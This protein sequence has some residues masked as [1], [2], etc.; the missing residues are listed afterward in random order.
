MYVC[1]IESCPKE[2]SKT[3]Y[4]ISSHLQEPL[5]HPWEELIEKGIHVWNHDYVDNPTFVKMICW[6]L[7]KKYLIKNGR[8][9]DN[10][11]NER[12]LKRPVKRPR[13]EYPITLN[14]KLCVSINN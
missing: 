1:P 2:P 9:L 7:E 3:I 12:E 13:P 10:Y 4:K 5:I 11:L 6:M 8:G 14:T